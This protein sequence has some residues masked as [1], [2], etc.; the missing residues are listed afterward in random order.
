MK[1]LLLIFL[2]GS[3]GVG[4]CDSN[5][6]GCV[7]VRGRIT[8]DGQPLTHGVVYFL[9]LD[10]EGSKPAVGGIS[11]DGQYHLRACAS[12]AGAQPTLFRVVVH[13]TEQAPGSWTNEPEPFGTPSERWSIPERYAT[14]ATS[15]LEFE[16]DPSRENIFDIRLVSDEKS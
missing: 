5:Q 16:V 2:L 7:T 8:L 9:D 1:R 4:G 15:G 3:L 14:P 6:S 13:V 11:A 12:Q 10:H